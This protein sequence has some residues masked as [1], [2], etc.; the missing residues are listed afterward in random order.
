MAE[1]LH[2]NTL[3]EATAMLLERPDA[4][5][6]GGGTAIQILRREGLIDP[7]VLVDLDGLA[8][9]R[10]IRAED[11]FLRIGAMATQREVELSDEVRDAASLL[12]ETYRHVANVR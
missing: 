10:G 1:I 4:R 3:A 7:P 6:L 2:P 12:C 5:A 9:R 8:E 11:G